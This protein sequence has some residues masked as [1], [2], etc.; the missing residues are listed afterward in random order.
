MSSN[1][2]GDGLTFVLSGNN[3]ELQCSFNPAIYLNGDYEMCM[4]SLQTYNSIPN[5][6]DN[7]NI[8]RYSISTKAY[9]WREIKI[10]EGTYDVED[11]EGYINK[12]LK[13]LEGED[14]VCFLE[15]NNNTMKVSLKATV[16]VDFSNEKSIGRLLGFKRKIYP[17]N[18]RYESGEVVDINNVSAID[19]MCNI[20]DGSYINGEP[21]HILYHFYPDVPPGYKIIEVPEQKIYMPVNTNIITNIVIR[22]VDQLGRVIHLRG[23]ELTVYSRIRRRGTN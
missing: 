21:S 6:K 2:V 4:V 5:V 16:D 17:R 8:F 12:Q 22:A 23:E 20:V 1:G 3:G 13:V 7:N 10:P 18:E 19:L 15:A 11:L 9:D 14:K